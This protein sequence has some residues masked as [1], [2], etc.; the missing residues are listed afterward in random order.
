MDLGKEPN[1][2]TVTHEDGSLEHSRLCKNSQ[3]SLCC[4]DGGR[5]KFPPP[6]EICFRGIENA[7]FFRL[8]CGVVNF[9]SSWLA[10]IK[11]V[12]REYRGSGRA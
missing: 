11:S 9:L 6:R 7:R 1:L 8:E 5:L 10:T 12:C 2:S 4:G 3:T